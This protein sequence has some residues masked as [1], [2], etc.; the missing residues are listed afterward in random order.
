M[1]GRYHDVFSRGRGSFVEPC[2]CLCCRNV[3]EELSDEGD[4]V[5]AAVAKAQTKII[6]QAR[7]LL[8]FQERG[9]VLLLLSSKR[10]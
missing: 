1:K 7:T 3:E 2:A 6:T 4:R 10:C 8:L 9:C 5:G